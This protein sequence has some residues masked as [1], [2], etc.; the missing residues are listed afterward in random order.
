MPR[1]STAPCREAPRELQ[2]T[3][4]MEPA[5]HWRVFPLK[6]ACR[7]VRF[8]LCEAADGDLNDATALPHRER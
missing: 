2:T 5:V 3:A 8:Q 4:D 7:L 1:L 6:Y